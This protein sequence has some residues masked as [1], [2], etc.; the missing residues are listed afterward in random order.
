[1][2]RVIYVASVFALAFASLNLVTQ[3]SGG[4]QSPMRHSYK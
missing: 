4:S 1:M 3:D 2:K